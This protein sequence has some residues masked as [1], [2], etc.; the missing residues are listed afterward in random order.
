[1]L[2]GESVDTSI[3]SIDSFGALDTTRIFY[4]ELKWHQNLDEYEDKFVKQFDPD[5]RLNRVS[6]GLNALGGDAELR[7]L[8]LF[9]AVQKRNLRI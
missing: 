2:V 8:E 9:N 6:G 4:R 3:L 5:Y 7:K 1:M